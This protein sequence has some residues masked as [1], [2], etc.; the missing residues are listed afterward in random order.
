MST[1]QIIR[2]KNGKQQHFDIKTQE[3]RFSQ[4]RWEGEFDGNHVFAS[5]MATLAS[6]RT[7]PTN[8]TSRPKLHRIS[9]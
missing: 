7:R 6:E 4:D 2:M 3:F 1:Y 5:K 8:I 9:Q